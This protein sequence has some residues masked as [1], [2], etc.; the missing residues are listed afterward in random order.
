MSK[1][2]SKTD[3]YLTG[4]ALENVVDERVHDRHGLGGDSSVGVDLL[5]D[6]V[7]VDGVSLLAGLSALLVSGR[8][9]GRLDGLLS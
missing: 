6:T 8:L 5:E 9:L 3:T 7:D 4:D 1:N 2:Q